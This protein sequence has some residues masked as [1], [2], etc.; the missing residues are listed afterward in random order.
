MVV[1]ISQ[2]SLFK[3]A[4]SYSTS[5]IHFEIALCRRR[6]DFESKN[7]WTTGPLKFYFEFALCAR[8]RKAKAALRVAAHE[9]GLAK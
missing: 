7:S 3:N 1:S 8:R 4:S 9:I 6:Q 5:K 2:D